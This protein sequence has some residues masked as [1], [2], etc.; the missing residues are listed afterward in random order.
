MQSMQPL[1]KAVFFA[2]V[3]CAT[4]FLLYYVD[5][6]LG[7]GWGVN[8]I[9]NWLQLG[10]LN[11]HGQLVYNPGGFD[12]AE[13]PIV[14]QGMSPVSLYPVFFAS[15][16]F[17]WSG[18]DTL[19]YDFFAV[20][21]LLWAI[22]RLLGRDDFA[23]IVAALALLC[24]GYMRCLKILDPNSLAVLP[25]LPFAVIMLAILRKPRLTPAQWVGL[26]IFTLAFM[27]LNWSTGWIF[28]P[29]LCLLFGMPGVNRRALIYLAGVMALGVCFV[30]VV[31]FA[32][33]AGVGSTGTNSGKIVNKLTGYLWGRGGYGEG[34]TT[35]RAF[36]RL[37]VVNGVGLLPLGLALVYATA[38]RMR[39][40]ARFPWFAFAPFA[41]T[42]LDIVIMRN[43][44]GHHPPLGGPLLLVGLVFSLALLR[45]PL[46]G[47]AKSAPEKISFKF[48]PALALAGFVYGLAVLVCFRAN[49]NNLL[50]VAHL[51]HQNTARTDVIVTVKANDPNTASQAPRLDEPLDRRVIV[52]DDFQA[53]AGETNHWML[54][55]SVNPG[56]SFTLVGQSTPPVQSW[57]SKP[58]EWFSRVVA[59]RSAND[60]IGLSGTYFLYV[61]A[62]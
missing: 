60:R 56:S 25:S 22:W 33:K 54:L 15:K 43:Y 21:I 3:F 37:V 29:C 57:W 51:I 16:I 58:G 1:R 53:L 12:I 52:V 55:T 18:L 34:L 59:R 27:S 32:L 24:P 41:L 36:L 40:G 4:I 28:A 46:P 31:S 38:Q 39:G 47:G 35:G 20:P 19:P 7:T 50:S 13:H 8:V 10:L 26:V 62:H 44:F 61:P 45:A 48:A 11:L 23:V 17:A 9:H 2:T 5:D 30:V 49:E 14:Y 6:N 42:I